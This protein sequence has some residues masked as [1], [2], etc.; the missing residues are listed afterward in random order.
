M[1]RVSILTISD[2]VFAGERED[3]SGL[4]LR[5]RAATLGWSLQESIAVP[6]DV[7]QIAETLKSWADSGSVDL[8]LST[9]GTGVALRDVTPEA[10]R[11]VI[12][13]EI[14]GIG[15]VMRAEGL[16]NTRMAPLSRSMAGTRGPVLI[17][18]L[19]GSPKGATES[20]AAIEHLISHMV[21]LLH[22]KTAHSPV[23]N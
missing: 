12:D 10:T 5:E 16:K 2:S 11:T 1:I 7:P 20:L 19:P 3:L 22:G 18:N 15:E 17:V 9:G 6:D 14:P 8:I 4:R 23:R 13:R 21:D